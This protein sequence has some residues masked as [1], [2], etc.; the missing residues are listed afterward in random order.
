[1]TGR[2]KN[3]RCLPLRF[4]IPLLLTSM[5]FAG[6]KRNEETYVRSIVSSVGPSTLLA[7]AAT[8]AAR[9]APKDGS[10]EAAASLPASFRAFAPVET[11]RYGQQIV[12]VTARHLQHR[13]GVA[14]QPIGHPEP[15]SVGGS[16]Y[17]RIAPGI[18][19]YES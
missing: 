11:W 3:I 18:Y 1:M 12:I 6:C 9:P 2:W 13:V 14:I 10:P 17:V 16:R 8:L 5:A 7:D 19:F 4:L 15:T